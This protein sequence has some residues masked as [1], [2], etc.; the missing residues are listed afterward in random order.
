[1]CPNDTLAYY[2]Y[3]SD[4]SILAVT[5][6]QLTVSLDEALLPDAVKH[7]PISI[8][9]METRHFTAILLPAVMQ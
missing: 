6:K 3:S 5:N 4:Q 9:L 7:T 2:I 8:I 1:M